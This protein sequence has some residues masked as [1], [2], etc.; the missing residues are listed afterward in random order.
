MCFS[1]L[2]G[3][4]TDFFSFYFHSPKSKKGLKRVSEGFTICTTRP[5]QCQGQRVTSPS[6]EVENLAPSAKLVLI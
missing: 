2:L 1:N 5:R 6:M 3:L 4:V